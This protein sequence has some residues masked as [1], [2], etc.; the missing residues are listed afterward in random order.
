[1]HN[2]IGDKLDNVI[3]CNL[4]HKICQL[5]NLIIYEQ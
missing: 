3:G 1:M 5:Q 4:A 2:F